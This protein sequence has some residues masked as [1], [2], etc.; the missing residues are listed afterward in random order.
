MKSKLNL[1][2]K[3]KLNKLKSAAKDKK[4]AIL[5]KNKKNVEDEKLQHELFLTIR[6]TAKIRYAFS[7]NKSTDSKVNEM[8]WISL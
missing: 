2:S 7:N 8:I 4:R 5:R 6:Q 3:L 1:K